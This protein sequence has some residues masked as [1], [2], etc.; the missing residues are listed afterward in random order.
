MHCSVATGSLWW[1]VL[2]SGSLSPSSRYLLY[3][4]PLS[5]WS[6]DEGVIVTY[7]HKGTFAIGSLWCAVPESESLSS[8]DPQRW[9]IFMAKSHLY[10]DPFQCSELDRDPHEKLDLGPKLMCLLY[11]GNYLVAVVVTMMMSPAINLGINITFGGSWKSWHINDP[12]R[13]SCSMLKVILKDNTVL[14][15]LWS[16]FLMKA[17]T[18]RLSLLECSK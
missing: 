12:T 5:P 16:F 6:S 15:Y 2:A 13:S 4:A 17:F 1:L 9:L 11:R 18:V 8:I 7:H 10:L 3:L 14:Y